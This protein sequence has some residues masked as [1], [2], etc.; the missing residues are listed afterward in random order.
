MPTA[1]HRASPHASPRASERPIPTR[2]RPLHQMARQQPLWLRVLMGR[3]L[4]PTQSEWRAMVDAL[5]EGD[6]AMDALV[7]WMFVS[8][9]RE[10]KQQFDRV[11]AEGVANVPDAPAPLRD[12]FTQVERE[13]AWLDWSLLEEGVSFIHRAGL[14][15]PYVLRDFALM[16]GYLQSGFNKALILTGALNK[17]ASQRIAETSKW[18]IDCTEHGGMR[19]GHAGF[20]STLHVR[21]VHAMVRRHLPKNP[22]WKTEVDGLPVNQIDMVATYLAFGPIM[23]MGIRALGIPVLP[24]ES[25]AVMHLWK[26]AGWLMGVQEKW[27]VDDER[28]GLLRVYQTNMTQSPPDWSSKELGVALSREPL[29]RI[30]PAWQQWPLLHEWR[31]KLMYQQH[32]SVTSLFLNKKQLGQLGLPDHV[33]PWFPL[34]SAGPR[35]LN[36]SVKRLLPQTRQRLEQEGRAEQLRYLTRMFGEKGKSIIKPGA[37]H[38]AHIR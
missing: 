7:E 18:W 25:K 34:I 12:F 4:A 38:P 29:T 37:Q 28:E 27:L 20:T 21:M 8:N 22:E 15:G 17:D 19:R 2:V 1:A 3:D 11:L 14:A 31:V 16:G 6:P 36:Y 33:Y 5:S 35:F 13:P 23:L 26:Y 24:S 10:A 9:P 30:L 32:L